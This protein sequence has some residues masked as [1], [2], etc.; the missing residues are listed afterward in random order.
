[1]DNRIILLLALS[2]ATYD[3]ENIIT[4]SSSKII[5]NNISN[6]IIRLGISKLSNKEFLIL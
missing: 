3:T 5:R 2:I 6:I 4:S 1:M